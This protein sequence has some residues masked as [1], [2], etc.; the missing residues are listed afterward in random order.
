[1]TPDLFVAVN[2]ETG[3]Y[4]VAVHFDDQ[5]YFDKLNTCRHSCVVWIPDDPCNPVDLDKYER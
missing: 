1:M 4:G 5:E 2:I 3:E